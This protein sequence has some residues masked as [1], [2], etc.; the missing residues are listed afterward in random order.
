MLFHISL[1][2]KVK[3]CEIVYCNTGLLHVYLDSIFSL[4]QDLSSL[5]Q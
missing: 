1:E 2:R 4:F 5:A 3:S